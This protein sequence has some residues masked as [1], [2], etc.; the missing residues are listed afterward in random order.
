MSLLRRGK[1]G[2]EHRP[3]A[4]F[5]MRLFH[6]TQ[7]YFDTPDT[8]HSAGKN[9]FGNGLY[10]TPN[11]R[12]ARFHMEK[13]RETQNYELIEYTFDDELAQADGLR[14]I[15]FKKDAEWA[16]F[17][18]ANRTNNEKILGQWGEYDVAIGP[19]ADDEIE[20]VVEYYSLCSD[21]GAVDWDEIIKR[22]DPDSYGE[23][24]L[25]HT[26]RSVSKRYLKEVNHESVEVACPKSGKGVRI[27]RRNLCKSPQ[28]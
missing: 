26:E 4:S 20:K 1:K 5:S 15:R 10:T 12:Y 25:F 28:A 9:D 11:E 27:L 21:R 3:L 19:S 14:I 8:K 16:R 2:R 13:I 6:S 24:V 23:Q 7:H 22:L 17:I 18:M